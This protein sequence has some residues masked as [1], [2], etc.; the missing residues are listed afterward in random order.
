MKKRQRKNKKKSIV[1][2]LIDILLTLIILVLLFLIA[3]DI[4]DYLSIKK[5]TEANKVVAFEKYKEPEK[6]CK[7]NQVTE[8]EDYSTEKM[9][10]FNWP[11]NDIMGY[12]K[13]PEQ[14]MSD[15]IVAGDKNDSQDIA[16]SKGVSFSPN[17]LLPSLGGTSVIAGHKEFAFKYLENVKIGDSIVINI[18]GN[19]FTYEITGTK[20][21]EDTDIDMVYLG[22]DSE[23]L[24]LYTCYPFGFYPTN[25]ERFAVY[26]KRVEKV[27]YDVETC[28]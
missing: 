17:S 10:S 22:N 25:T 21:I 3:S 4:S 14:G 9:Q 6:V 27:T 19:I 7:N 24:V 26:A 13:L 23:S 11:T 12:I 16:M 28:E 1:G 8:T 15:A 20:I 5:E 2:K 18:D